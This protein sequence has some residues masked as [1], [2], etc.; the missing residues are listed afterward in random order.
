[1]GSVWTTYDTEDRLYVIY[2]YP[3]TE[4]KTC[5]G[6]FRQRARDLNK[7]CDEFDFF[8]AMNAWCGEDLPGTMYFGLWLDKNKWVF[9]EGVYLDS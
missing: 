7:F 4:T 3:R 1:M 9:E 2:D 6:I 5:R 8:I